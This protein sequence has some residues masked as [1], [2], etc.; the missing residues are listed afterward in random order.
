MRY[1]IGLPHVSQAGRALLAAAAWLRADPGPRGGSRS[2]FGPGPMRNGTTDILLV[3]HGQTDANASGTLQGHLPTP[4]NLTGIRQA[5]LLADRLAAWRPRVAALVSSDLPR[6]AQTAGP[7]AAACGLKIAFDP[8]WRERAFGL[9]EGKAVVDRSLWQVAGGEVDPPGAEPSAEFLARVRAALTALATAH[10][11]R[12]VVAVV[13]HGGPMRAVLRM[14]IDGRLELVRG[15]RPVELVTIANCS[16]L[17]LR[18]RHYRSGTRWRVS[19]VNDVAHL[20]DLVT[21]R[22][23]G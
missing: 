23:M 22:D 12:P 3:R 9:L 17:R 13:T 7:V 15:H 4:L 10:R 5:Q 2:P 16:L 19:A 20:G 1:P 6:A 8:R 14:L 18:A 21:T 11:H